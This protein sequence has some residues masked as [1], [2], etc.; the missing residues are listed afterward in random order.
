M[1]FRLR[2]LSAFVTSLILAL[3][4]MAED[5]PDPATVVAKVG[6]TEITLG[7]MLALR[8]GLPP[9]YQELPDEVLFD[10][11][12]DQL[13][14]QSLLMQMA[15]DAPT[16]LTSLMIENETRAL[17]AAQAMRSVVDQ[18]ISDAA[19]QDA[20]QK[21]FA[22]QN[23]E[24]EYHAAHIL[25]ASEQEAKDI[26]AEL[27][28]GADFAELAKTRST[29]PS[30]PG[31]GDL[32]WFGPGMM[33]QP[34]FDAVEA[35]EPG[36]YSPPVETE[37]GWHVIHLIETRQ[38]EVPTLDDVREDLVSEIRQE[39]FNK[40]LETRKA[41]TDIDLSGAEG[42]DPSIIKKTDILEN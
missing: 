22:G 14:Q 11:I 29:G 26:L 21:E 5:M 3:P 20:Y 33:V 23:P 42:I 1:F 24:N 7:H 34:F 2:F 32:G 12:L 10:G 28:N 8:N 39:A 38:R 25:V 15:E 17:L 4:A 36:K 40:L 41:E 35:L 6:E 19:L 16:P 27:E 37:F 13:V 18:P 31:G 9:Q 30:G